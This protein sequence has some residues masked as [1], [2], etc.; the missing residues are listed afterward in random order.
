MERFLAGLWEHN[1]LIGLQWESFDGQKS[2]RHDKYIAP[3]FSWA[4]RIGPVVWYISSKYLTINRE[5]CDYAEILDIQCETTPDAPLGRVSSGYIKL[6]GYTTEMQFEDTDGCYIQGRLKLLKPASS[7]AL[8]ESVPIQADD[9]KEPEMSSK[10]DGRFR[11]S[12]KIIRGAISLHSNQKEKTTTRSKP[13]KFRKEVAYVCMDAIDDMLTARGKV[14]TC[15]DIMRDKDGEYAS[16]LILLP[17]DGK[18]G[19]FR[20]V[21][22]S[23]MTKA[24]FQG[25][26]QTE[27]T[28][29]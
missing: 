20:R 5:K 27:V 4:S 28:V 16:A 1:I 18:P 23:T 3:S 2:R 11:Q 17:L 6:R 29:V 22:F 7:T 9:T 14:V 13:S 26:Q 10:T 25:A 12:Q 19:K 21:G 15:L 24:L 8:G